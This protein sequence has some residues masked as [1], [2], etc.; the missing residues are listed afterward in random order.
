MRTF[1][2]SEMIIWRAAKVFVF[3]NPNNVILTSKLIEPLPLR[4]SMELA[5]NEGPSGFPF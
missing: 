4:H 2:D 5:R 3:G 1:F